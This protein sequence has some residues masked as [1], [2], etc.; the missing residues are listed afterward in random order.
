MKNK[1]FNSIEKKSKK[2]CFIPAR[3]GSTRVK[4]KNIRTLN[5]RPLIYWTVSKA[6]NSK[7]FDKIIFSSDT[8][9]YYNILIKFLKKDKLDYRKLV[10]DKRASEH[11]NK[12]AKIFDYIK[13]DLSKKFNLKKNDLLVQMLPTCPLRS[14]NSI[15]KAINYS[16]LNN[17]NTFSACEYDFHLKFCFSINKK[18]WKSVFKK[19][20]MISGNTQSQSQKKYYHPTG[21]IN[22]LFVKT[23]NKN[24]KSIYEGALPLVIPRSESF[25]IDTEDDFKILKKIFNN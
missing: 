21:V 16:I 9:K 12:K 8:E 14:I 3:S 13:Y 23:L 25:D 10:F 19:S 11:S 4:N 2:I 20:P 22:C 5:G 7:Q 18:K 15:K 17:K 6:L 24:S 1:S